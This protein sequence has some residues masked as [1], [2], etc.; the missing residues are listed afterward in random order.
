MDIKDL[1]VKSNDDMKKQIAHEHGKTTKEME[2][3]LDIV[4]KKR[5]I[6]K[7]F[8]KKKVPNKKN[9]NE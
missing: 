6:E 3:F 1:Y 8:I 4:K 5:N 2:I 9:K 7:I